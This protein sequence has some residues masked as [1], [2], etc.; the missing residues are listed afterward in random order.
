[1]IYTGSRLPR[2]HIARRFGPLPPAPTGEAGSFPAPGLAP[3]PVPGELGG[4]GEPLARARRA[5]GGCAGRGARSPGAVRPRGAE[6]GPGAP[7][8]GPAGTETARDPAPRHGPDPTAPTPR[9]RT[10]PHPPLA[11]RA[12]AL[13]RSSGEPDLVPG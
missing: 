2:D 10:L 4:V 1:M 9:P 11:G 7:S 6:G 8:S 13:R 3:T 12:G 5:A